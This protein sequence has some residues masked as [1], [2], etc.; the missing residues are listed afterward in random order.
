MAKRHSR[1]KLTVV[2]PHLGQG[3]ILEQVLSV[4]EAERRLHCLL[5]WTVHGW[6]SHDRFQS[7]SSATEAKHGRLVA[8]GA[9][10]K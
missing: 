2:G 6:L 3:L 7:T 10:Q 1:K 5:K 4:G 9:E 8:V